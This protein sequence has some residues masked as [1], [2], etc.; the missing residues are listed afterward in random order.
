MI[1]GVV[2]ANCSRVDTPPAGLPRKMSSSRSRVPFRYQR[3]RGPCGPSVR[4]SSRR[5]RVRCA[6]PLSTAA[7]PVERVAA[8]P[9]RP[10]RLRPVWGARPFAALWARCAAFRGRE[11]VRRRCRTFASFAAKIGRLNCA[12]RPVS[13]GVRC[14]VARGVR[15]VLKRARPVGPCGP[16]CRG[17]WRGVAR[18]VPFILKRFPAAFPQKVLPFFARVAAR[19]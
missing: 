13:G 18:G 19:P 6:C 4:E 7:R 10:W 8:R 12:A 1:R 5:G 14:A 16:L 15:V 3:R 17:A 2:V 11:R 9:L